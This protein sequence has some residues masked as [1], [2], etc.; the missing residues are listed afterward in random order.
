MV[1]EM[2]SRRW[3]EFS[4]SGRGIKM[5]QLKSFFEERF[6]NKWVTH[7][8]RLARHHLQKGDMW[9]KKL[10][11]QMTTDCQ[12]NIENFN[13]TCFKNSFQRRFG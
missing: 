13:L 8:W 7:I 2:K 3:L 4:H 10:K 12:F 5:K 11:T 1:L 9:L 6:V